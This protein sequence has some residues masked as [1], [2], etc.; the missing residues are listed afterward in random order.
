MATKKAAT[1]TPATETPATAPTTPTHDLAHRI[2]PLVVRIGRDGRGSGL[3]V[4]P[5]K[6]LTNAHNLRNPTVQVMLADGTVTQGAVTATDPDGDLAII[7]ITS[8]SETTSTLT[9]LPWAQT[10]AQLGDVVHTVMVTATGVRSTSGAVSSVGRAFSGPRGRMIEGS[11]EHTAPIARGGS[12]SPLLAAD[13]SLLGINTHRLGDGFY[14]ALPGDERTIERIAQLIAGQSPSDRRLGVALARPDV[15]KKL[16][17]S[18][19]LTERDGLLIRGVASDGPGARAELV[20]GDLL[21]SAN[22][23]PLATVA[24]LETVL[25][26]LP[27]DAL[28]IELGVVRGNDERT[29]TVTF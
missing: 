3:L 11:I 24:D 4:A 27:S 21:V 6:V 29:V 5:S 15:A 10:D 20:E 8:D 18:V 28:T 19:G 2:A 13:G 23:T 25:R 1:E 9:F 16:R 7:D 12:G 17:R 26:S 14:L 22:A